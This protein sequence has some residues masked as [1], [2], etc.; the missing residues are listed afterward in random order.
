[1]KTVESVEPDEN[2][3]VS[4][5][6]NRADDFSA[7]QLDGISRWQSR[8]ISASRGTLGKDHLLCSHVEVEGR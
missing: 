7:D 6:S 1:M 2:S 4:Q 8:G 3:R 5:C